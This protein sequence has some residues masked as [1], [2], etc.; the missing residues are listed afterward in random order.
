LPGPVLISSNTGSGHP[1]DEALVAAARRLL[2]RGAWDNIRLLTGDAAITARAHPDLEAFVDDDITAALTD[3]RLMM[4]VGD[5]TGHTARKRAAQHVLQA[6]AAGVPVALVS[7]RLGSADTPTDMTDDSIQILAKAESFTTCDGASANIL[8]QCTGRRVATTAPL[9][10]VLSAKVPPHSSQQ[11]A[12]EEEFLQSLTSHEQQIMLEAVAAIATTHGLRAVVVCAQKCPDVQLPDSIE[13]VAVRTWT[14][15]MRALS[16]V[17][18]CLGR[19]NSIA[20]HLA[21]AQ[22]AIPLSN[23]SSSAADL[24]ERIGLGELSAGVC[25]ESWRLLLEQ[26]LQFSTTDVCARSTPL[27]VVAWRALGSLSEAVRSCPLELQQD[28]TL[29]AAVCHLFDQQ[30][31]EQLAVGDFAV[32]ETHLK[33]WEQDLATEPG[34][35]AAR[36][37]VWTMQGADSAARTLLEETLTADPNHTQCLSLLAM[38]LWRLGDGPAAQRCWKRIVETGGEAAVFAQQQWD[39]MQTWA[40]AQSPIAVSKGTQCGYTR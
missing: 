24:T 5:L 3:C 13:C 31:Q 38:V 9:E 16:Q 10:L 6:K 40:T 18:I 26:A 29:R 1:S 17:R 8:L 21:V 28:D 27:R 25:A 36:A 15:W 14:Q 19:P 22:G 7:V 37:R 12:I 4:V 33:Q 30:W 32:V 23:N 39:T 11:I 34:W 20:L 2:G 35:A